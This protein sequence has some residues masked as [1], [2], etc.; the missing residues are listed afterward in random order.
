M[1]Q[2]AA[3]LP[4]DVMDILVERASKRGYPVLQPESRTAEDGETILC[5]FTKTN[6]AD[7]D[8]LW[9]GIKGENDVVYEPTNPTDAANSAKTEGEVEPLGKPEPEAIQHA[10]TAKEP[11]GH[12][13]RAARNRAGQDEDEGNE[14]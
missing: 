8:A 1:T 13:Q 9:V 5:K 14:E 12:Q 7:S 2:T 11:R 4:K 3:Q 10:A 6:N